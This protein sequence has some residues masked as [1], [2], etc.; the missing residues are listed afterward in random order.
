MRVC[1][2]DFEFI[3]KEYVAALK[4]ENS[5]VSTEKTMDSLYARNRYSQTYGHKWMYDKK[6][7]IKI[8][9]NCNFRNIK[10]L[11]KNVLNGKILDEHTE[12]ESII[13]EAIK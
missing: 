13:L 10:I 2:P 9:K 3:A 6:Y 4:S 11:K 8:L 12:R 7:L 1:V 5:E